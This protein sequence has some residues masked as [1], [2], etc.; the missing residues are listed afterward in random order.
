[1]KAEYV[2]HMGNDLSVVNAARVSFA[3]Q[4]TVLEAGDVGL[5]QY[6]ARHN[7]WTPFAHTAI[8]LRM[9]APVPLRTQCFKHKQG[10]VENEE[11][12]RY[13][14]TRPQ[15]FMPEHFRNKPEGSIKQGSAG[16][17]P[18]SPEWLALY[19]TQC[20]AAI[21]LYQAMIDDGVAPE[22]ARF[23]LPQGVEVSWI[24]TGSLYAFANFVN[25]RRDPHAQREIQQLADQVAENIQPLFPLSWAALTQA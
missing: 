18:N 13:I 2:D 6:L 3:K 10:L 16:I 24:W 12:R 23:V 17:H 5:I 19:H 15:L 4:K 25:K 11:S 21:A 14:T 7:H 22:Q 8:S 1:M 20:E 9:Q